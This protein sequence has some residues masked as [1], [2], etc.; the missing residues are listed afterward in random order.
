[1]HSPQRESI[2]AMSRLGMSVPEAAR[3]LG[4][5]VRSVWRLIAAGELEARKIGRR[6]VIEAVTLNAYLV[7][8]PTR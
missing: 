5:G 1:M 7:S 8:R 3:Q 2:P 4:I 6:T